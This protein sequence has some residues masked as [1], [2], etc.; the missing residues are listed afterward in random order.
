MAK[1]LERMIFILEAQNDKLIKKLDESDRKLTAFK[2]SSDDNAK[3]VTA[4]L[5]GMF[6]AF[7]AGAS[8]VTFT[9][10]IIEATRAQEQL[11]RQLLQVTGN[12]EKASQAMRQLEKIAANAPFTV[13]QLTESFV[14]LKRKGLDTSAEALTG[15]GNLASG[16]GKSLGEVTAAVE[17][18]AMGQTRA[19]REFGIVAKTEGENLILTF[20][21]VST[22]VRN[23]GQDIQ[24][25]LADLGNTRFAGAM[26]A[27]L[28]TLS[29]QFAKLTENI[30]NLFEQNAEAVSPFKDAL[31]DLNK[32][33]SDP[34]FKSA[35]DQ[36]A[37]VAINAFSQMLG[38]ITKVINAT[39]YLGEELAAA[40]H[41]PA[42]GDLPRLNDQ[43]AESEAKMKA[44][45]QAIKD[46]R[47][48]GGFFDKMDADRYQ[49]QAEELQKTIDK[50]KEMIAITERGIESQQRLK[51]NPLGSTGGAVPG[52]GPAAG[53]GAGEESPAVSAASKEA[54]KLAEIGQKNLERV[55]MELQTAE[56]AI[57]ESYV[58]REE[59]ILANTQAGSELQ[60]ELL[61]KNNERRELEISRHQEKIG[62]IER[63]AMT[64]RQKFEA[65]TTGQRTK[66]VIGSL[67]EMTQGVATH[68]KTM[69]KI[70]KAA[71]I[72]NAI[73]N[74]AAGITKAL[75][76][77]PPPLS[78]AMAAAQ[79]AA[80]FAQ[81]SA[82]KSTEF[83]G[84]GSGTTPSAAGGGATVNSIPT[85]A[86]AGGNGAD[87]AGVTKPAQVINVSFDSR[88]TDT[89][90]IRKFIENEFAEALGD[91]VK[92]SAAIK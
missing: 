91:G 78:F 76:T 15:Y 71:G 55:I 74:T 72:A 40:I 11:D 48:A 1:D 51:F 19:L 14:S 61:V 22:T 70:N 66:M 60:F 43:L 3:A 32:T 83:E 34:A 6:G 16:F 5:A 49:R 25:Y 23:N 7:A 53:E 67:I 80:G 92:I 41:G 69:F 63:K 39:Q 27:E 26:G 45:Q 90:A 35:F 24:R 87:V 31:V 8:I 13:D 50:T 65:M 84:G 52:G 58:R 18:A 82:I 79:A 2:K 57:N 47:E 20:N 62:Q 21:G 75:A 36:L 89:A 12:T 81:V 44:L 10:N 86:A 56:E 54:E 85:A 37:A 64:D 46:R 29:G 68:S 33:I 17:S 38:A 4:S 30:D 42:I 9:K 77:Y 88:I 28:N 59:V 73:V